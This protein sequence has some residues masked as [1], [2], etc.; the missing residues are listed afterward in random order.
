MDITEWLRSLGFEQYATA[1]EDH[2]IDIR[3]LPELTAEDLKDLGVGMIGHRRL[4]LRAI[5]DLRTRPAT[6][7]E[8][9]A[10]E[11]RRPARPRSGGS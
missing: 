4:L 6:A 10:P 9:S 3:V 11:A 7:P 1:F 2:G 8:V 5:A